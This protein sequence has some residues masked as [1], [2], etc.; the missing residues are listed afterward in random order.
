VPAHLA[1]VTDS[2]Q[3]SPIRGETNSSSAA[4]KAAPTGTSH[5]ML[6][7]PARAARPRSIGQP[8]LARTPNSSMR[9]S[10][11]AGSA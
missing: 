4:V 1:D 3:L 9:A 8:W 10:I 7:G 2:S 6:S 5:Y 11:P